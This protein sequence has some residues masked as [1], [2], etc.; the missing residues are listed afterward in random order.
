MRKYPPWE[1]S[2]QTALLEG[3]AT[4]DKF[5]CVRRMIQHKFCFFSRHSYFTVSS[6]LIL[7]I[8]CNNRHHTC[9][10]NIWMG[11]RITQHIG[12]HLRLFII[13]R[14]ELFFW[15]CTTYKDPYHLLYNFAWADGLVISNFIYTV[16]YWC[17]GKNPSHISVLRQRASSVLPLKK[18]QILL[19]VSW[20]E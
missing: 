1:F 3:P 12:H 4:V 7:G 9:H 15:I 20:G 19:L 5:L 18:L 11:H 2:W 17:L 10:L 13:T 16:Y 6:I 14:R 8:M